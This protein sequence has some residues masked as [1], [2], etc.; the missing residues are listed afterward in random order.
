MADAAVL[1]RTLDEAEWIGRVLD[2]VLAQSVRPEVIVL[3]SGS[4]DRTVA[5]AKARPAVKVMT[6]AP[7]E[8]TYGR[9]LNR[10]FAAATAPFLVALSGHALPVD[11]RWLERLLAPFADPAVA[12]VY[13]RQLPHKD[14]DPFRTGE[15]LRYWHDRGGDDRPGASRYS[16]ANGAVRGE[17]W[18]RRPFDEALPAAE[19]HE[20]GNWALSEG[21]RVVYDPSA[22]VYHS[23]AESVW[24]RYKRNRAIAIAD[25]TRE[26]RADAWR[27]FVALCKADMR[28][29]AKQPKRWAWAPYSPLVRAAEV[30]ADRSAPRRR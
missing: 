8:F 11:E 5:E 3:D 4:T 7:S 6:I 19:D 28:M 24:A 21:H 22:A 16:N 12:A 26:S 10:G 30:I 27:R 17:L 18:K 2:A 1:I 13:G 9:A 23:H 15:V 20:W 29:I 14:L 25:K